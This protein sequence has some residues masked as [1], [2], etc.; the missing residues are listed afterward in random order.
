MDSNNG[1]QGTSV[2]EFAVILLVLFPLL[3]GIIE[4]GFIVYNQVMI[5]NACREGARYG[6]MSRADKRTVVEI[7]DKVK[8]YSD[9]I[10]LL[11]F[12][13][14][15]VLTVD[16][17]GRKADDPPDASRPLDS[18]VFGDVLTVTVTYPYT[19]LF[20]PFAQ[21]LELSATVMMKY[22]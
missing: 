16:P 12:D 7:R 1:E 10:L 11:S 2:V 20:L 17:I 14:L 8:E 9:N 18:L 3:F 15:A 6:I 21:P 5:T 19:Y 4:F 22:E 13:D